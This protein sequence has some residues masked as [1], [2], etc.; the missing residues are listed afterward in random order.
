MNTIKTTTGVTDWKPSVVRASGLRLEVRN[1]SKLSSFMVVSKFH[2]CVTLLQVR[3][4]T[5][6][7]PAGYRH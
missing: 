6:R 1:C 7:T 4:I 3:E 2:G 5:G